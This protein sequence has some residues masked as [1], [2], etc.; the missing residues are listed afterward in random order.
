MSRMFGVFLLGLIACA[1]AGVFADRAEA[2]TALASW[3]GP[4]FAGNPTASG[5]P[6]DPSAFTAAHKTLPLG[7]Q[8]QVSYNGRSVLV[9]VNDR[10]PYVPGRELDLSQAAAEYLGL[11]QAGV[12]Y[13]TYNYTG[14]VAYAGDVSY[15]GGSGGY[16]AYSPTAPQA[17]QA[18]YGGAGAQ[19]G[20]IY[21]VQPGDT[22]YG[23]AAELGTTVEE[24]AAANGIADP[25]LIVPGQE[26]RY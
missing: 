17:Q 6:Y 3:Y 9:T 12:D 15:G 7:T 2:E 25:N 20:G 18:T 5:E 8:L 23:I 19:Q 16:N 1:A 22:L 4:G 11:T 21:V 14:D 24:L 13:V 10:G 26:I